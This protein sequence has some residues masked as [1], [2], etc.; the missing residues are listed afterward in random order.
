MRNLILEILKSADANREICGVAVNIEGKPRFI[1]CRNIHQ[2]NDN[3]TIHPIDYNICTKQNDVLF[4]VHTHL[5]GNPN[6]SEA[7][8]KNLNLGKYPWLI[9][10][11]LSTAHTVTYPDG[12]ELPFTGR[13]F[14]HGIVDCYTLVSDYYKTLGI[15]L[16]H[17]ERDDDWWYNDKD[18]FYDDLHEKYG[19]VKVPLSDIKKNDV[20]IMK[21]GEGKNNHAAIYMGEN[22]ILHHAPKRLSCK[23]LLD[24]YWLKQVQYA[25]RYQGA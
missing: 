11:V 10:D 5:D 7:D 2:D 6:P 3:F 17:Y 8:M 1:K 15:S 19:F 13:Q 9:V 23:E 21:L 16:P 24:G 4:V 14:I 18:N 22:T 20:V 12:Y 25:L